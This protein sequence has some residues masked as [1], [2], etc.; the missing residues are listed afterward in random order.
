M[1]ID[2]LENSGTYELL[3]KNLPKAFEFIRQHMESLPQDGRYEIDG[4]NIYALVQSY[5]TMPAQ[6]RMW[7]S[8]RRYMDVQFMV[9]GSEVMG[10]APLGLL[11]PI[12]EYKADNDFIGYE[13]GPSTPLLCTA[14]TFVFFFPTDMHKPCCTA[15]KTCRVRKI[16]VK[17]KL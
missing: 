2:T 17:I 10:W 4:D 12:G 16:V 7:E 13:D 11:A 5:D 8:H 14:G 3:H 15:D 9:E 1:V 6:Q